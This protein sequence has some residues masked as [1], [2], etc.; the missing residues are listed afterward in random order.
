MNSRRVTLAI[1]QGTTSTRAILFD[2]SGRELSAARRELLQIY[3]CEGWVEH[4]PEEIW[5][6]TLAVIEETLAGEGAKGVSIAG[7]GIT[8]QRE[9]TIVWERESGRAIHNA[10][11]WQDRRTAPECEGLRAQGFELE[12]SKRSGLL[13]DPYFSATKLAWILD[14]VEGARAR[15]ERGELAFGTVDSFLLWRLT[16]GR[17]F[18]T[19]ATNA[20]RTGLFNLSRAEWDP[21]LLEIFRIPEAVLPEVQDCTADFGETDPSITGIGEQ[22]PILALVGDQQSAAIGQ[23]CIRPGAAKATYGTGC[24]VLLNVGERLVLSRNRL[25]STIA[26][27][28]DGQVSY[29][30]EGSIFM[31]GGVVQWLRDG[32]GV[33]QRAEMSERLARSVPGTGGVYLVPAFA[34]LGAP[35]WDA[36]A[37]GSIHGLT[38]GTGVAEIVRAGLEAVVYQTHDLLR[39]MNADGKDTS[40]LRVDGAMAANDWLMEFLASILGLPV[41]RPC[42][43]ETTSLGA[44]MLAALQAGLLSSLDDIGA[45]REAGA[46]FEPDMD[47]GGREKLLAGWEDAVRRTR[48]DA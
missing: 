33:I 3:P 19:D 34:G 11:V 38:R 23:G 25:L 18:K 32:L 42:N 13:L 46:R 4:A 24:F 22:L 26:W 37:R 41:E 27:R 36:N 48:T 30:L 21:K 6:A 16:G 45:R 29:A 2:P 47:S 17:V 10:I 31:A 39:A 7:I 12:I 40:M 44:G 9:T 5:S 8:N 15:A 43:L 1:D 14:R 35:H 28:V 20:S